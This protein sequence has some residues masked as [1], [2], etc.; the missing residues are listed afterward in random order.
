MHVTALSLNFLSLVSFLSPILK[1]RVN[2]LLLR[3][4]FREVIHTKM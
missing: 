1:L 4:D 2:Q 3:M